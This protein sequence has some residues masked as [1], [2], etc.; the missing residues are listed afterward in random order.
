MSNNSKFDFH[1]GS[2]VEF[3]NPDDG[4]YYDG[5][6]WRITQEDLSNISLFVRFVA[7]I[8]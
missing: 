5:V 7:P 2:I 4:K 6:I 1:E 3:R 8:I